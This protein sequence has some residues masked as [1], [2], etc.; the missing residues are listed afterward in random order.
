MNNKDCEINSNNFII[1]SDLR[2][3]L[4]SNKKSIIISIIGLP[5]AGKSTFMN[6]IVGEKISA[7][8][9]RVQTTRNPIRGI[10]NINET[11]LIFIDS[12][13]V[14]DPKGAMDEFMW[15]G[16]KSAIKDSDLLMVILDVKAINNPNFDLII[17]HIKKYQQKEKILL[18][19]KIDCIKTQQEL[20]QKTQ[21]I[22]EKFG[23]FFKK[24][25]Y[26]SITENKGIEELM[27][28]LIS[29]ASNPTWIYDEDQ[30]CNLSSKFCAAEITREKV[31][32]ILK[33]ELPY[34]I[35]VETQD[36]IEKDGLITISQVIYVSKQA[37]KSIVIGANA[38]M[39]KKIGIE[40]RKD[41]ESI[42]GTQINLK[43]FVKVKENWIKNEHFI[44]NTIG[45]EGS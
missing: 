1:N 26:I 44:R 35:M 9:H 33:M 7:I 8:S 39:I 17:N 42:F 5:N 22:Q 19:N 31:F 20:E 18:V 25:F 16:T 29:K 12:P 13:G 37:H 30:V 34:S 27:E 38:S 43:L 2:I 41:L 32:N 40:S 23:E 4:D 24:Y 3:E 14:I 28:Y 21:Q 36:W 45:H 11:Q 6:S 10:K 15:Q